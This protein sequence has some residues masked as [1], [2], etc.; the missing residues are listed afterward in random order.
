MGKQNYYEL[1]LIEIQ[2]LLSN[3]Q[4]E[5]ALDLLNEE[6]SLSYIP[7]EYETIFSK[8]WVEINHQKKQQE[9]INTHLNSEQF[10][11]YLFSNDNHKLTK[12]ISVIEEI[13]LKPLGSVLKKWIEDHKNDNWIAKVYMI[14]AMAAQ[15]INI[16]IKYKQTVINPQKFGSIFEQAA[17]RQIFLEISQLTH[18]KVYLQNFVFQN[19][20]TFLL[21]NYPEI[22][23]SKNL[24]AIL[25]KITEHMFDSKI[26]L[27]KQELNIF[28]QIKNF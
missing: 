8:L 14:E 2:N 3:N 18:K 7:L 1:K 12:A 11:D 17:I 26:K 19:F 20:K 4:I 23:F 9:N 27:T 5:Q 21:I 24:T 6:L 10:V 25:I 16:D 13:N 15:E 22:K 28:N